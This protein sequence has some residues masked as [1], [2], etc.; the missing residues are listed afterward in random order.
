MFLIFIDKKGNF[1]KVSPKKKSVGWK[2]RLKRFFS[3]NKL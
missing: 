1:Y 3:K 2:Y